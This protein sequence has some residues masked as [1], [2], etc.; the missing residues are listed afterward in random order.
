MLAGFKGQKWGRE[1][2]ELPS[3]SA[4]G[5]KICPARAA[6]VFAQ[7]KPSVASVSVLA[8]SAI[9]PVA[10]PHQLSSDAAALVVEMCDLQLLALD[11][12]LDL[13]SRQWS[14]FAAVV[15]RNQSVRQNYEAQIATSRLIAPGQYRVEIPAYASAGD[16]LRKKFNAELRTELGEAT[17][18]EVLANLGAR[19]EGRFA[20]FGVS[21]QTLDITG[22]PS[23]SLGDVQVTRTVTYWNSVDGGD[24]LTTR[25]ETHFPAFEDPTGDSWIALLAMVKA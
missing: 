2:A 15:L 16:L 22:N 20:G 18:A 21:V 11:T 19:L 4:A 5:R 24:R 14:A 9:S 8:R 13:N 3:I 25:R 1:K 7:E 10:P 17:A 12:H 23:E 6:S